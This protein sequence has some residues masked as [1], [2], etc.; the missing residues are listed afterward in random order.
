MSYTRVK[1]VALIGGTHGNEL[2]G[3]YLIKKFKNDL[4]LT[5]RDSF[6]TI[7]LLGNPKAIKAR[8]RY[9]DTDLNRCFRDEDLD[10]NDF[11]NY[12]QLLAKQHKKHLIDQ[13]AVDIIID[14]HTTTSDMGMTLILHDNNPFLLQLVAY[15]CHL[16]PSIN[17]LQY[18]NS[19]PCQ[20]RSLAKIGLGIEVGPIPQGVLKADIFQKTEALIMQIFDYIQNYNTQQLPN[21]AKSLT[22]YKQTGVMDYPRDENNKIR[23]M[24]FPTLKDYEP[25]QPNDPIFID[26]NGDIIKYQGNSTVWPVF[27]NEAAYVEKGIAM[28]LTKKETVTV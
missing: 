20:L 14:I 4:S 28:S 6:E 21:I 18:S 24:I 10:K 16:Y 8:E 5:E 25:L 22:L 13:E 9:I 7:T 12:E 2:I 19:Q 1:K 15:L 27:I 17:V 3:V 11:T 23:A 26:F